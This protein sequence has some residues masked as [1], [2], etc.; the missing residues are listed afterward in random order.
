M[1]TYEYPDK[2][3]RKYPE[4]FTNDAF[5]DNL[6]EDL[7]RLE[8]ACVAASGN[9]EGA[10]ERWIEEVRRIIR[11]GAD[12]NAPLD[13]DGLTPLMIACKMGTWPLVKALVEE[14]DADLDGPISRAGFRAIDYAGYE[15]FRFPNEHPITCYLKSKGSQHTWWGAL[16]AGDLPRV[17]EYIDH[18]QDIDEINPVL[19]NGNGVWHA[20]WSGN[21]R[22]MQY[23]I[24]RGGTQAIR[25]CHNPDT[26]EDMWSIGRGDA[27]YY[28]EQKLT[29]ENTDHGHIIANGVPHY[30]EK[31]KGPH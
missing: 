14:M 18:G 8:N 26:H 30:S 19:W 13:K 7:W 31:K 9:D 12:V 20:M 29:L 3:E 27:F 17:A 2:E 11:C 5:R 1:P 24:A 10:N 21:A 25:N 23:L 28:K 16:W 22:V 15:G 6:P 4:R